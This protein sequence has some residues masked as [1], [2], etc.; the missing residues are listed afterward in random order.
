MYRA[1]VSSLSRNI[2][3]WSFTLERKNSHDAS[4]FE[5]EGR[6]SATAIL[7]VSFKVAGRMLPKPA[8][9]DIGLLI[10]RRKFY[11]VNLI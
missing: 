8:S 1:K 10:Y 3:K 9:V 7:T 4:V 5:R 2:G 6:W 11:L